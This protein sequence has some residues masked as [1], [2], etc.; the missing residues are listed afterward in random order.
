MAMCQ[1][2]VAGSQVGDALMMDDIE[3]NFLV[4][5]LA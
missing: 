1:G 5:V 3:T 2:R 4:T